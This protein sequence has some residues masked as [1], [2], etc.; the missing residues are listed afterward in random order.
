MQVFLVPSPVG[1]TV[2]VGQKMAGVPF[3]KVR[4]R[5]NV[6]NP[7]VAVGAPLQRFPLGSGARSPRVLQLLNVRLYR[8]YAVGMTFELGPTRKPVLA[9]QDQKRLRLSQS[10]A[11]R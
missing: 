1:E 2:F 9:C 5:R 3:G 11:R 8:S 7:R 10:F 6:G 4:R